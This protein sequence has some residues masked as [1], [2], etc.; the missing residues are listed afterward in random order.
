M[1]TK[2]ETQKA[3]DAAKAFIKKNE[4][5]QLADQTLFFISGYYMS[6]DEFYIHH[7]RRLVE[8]AEKT[9]EACEIVR[10]DEEWWG[11]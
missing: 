4:E 1:T 10:E 5:D 3:V 8:A 7:L 6:S 2:K 9:L 11:D